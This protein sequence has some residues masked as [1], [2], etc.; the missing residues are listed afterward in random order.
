VHIFLPTNDGSGR[1]DFK[2]MLR[3]EIRVA[4]RNQ[5]ALPKEK[6]MDQFPKKDAPSNASQPPKPAEAAED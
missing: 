6:Q 2:C 3:S 5:L 1:S 4:A